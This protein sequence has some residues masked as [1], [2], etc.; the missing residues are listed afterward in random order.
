MNGNVLLKVKILLSNQNRTI[1]AFSVN[2]VTVS[3]RTAIFIILLLRFV[4]I[5]ITKVP[6]SIL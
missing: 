3:R 1:F 2:A 5:L 6:Q 4:E